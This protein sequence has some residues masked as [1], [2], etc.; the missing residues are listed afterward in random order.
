M[1]GTVINA[2]A[3]IAGSLLG[4]LIRGGLKEKYKEMVMHV[5]GLCVLFVGASSAL[6]GLLDAD[7]EPVLFIVS[8]VLG[9]LCGQW[10]DIEGRLERLGQILQNKIGNK[11]GNIAQGFVS[12][13]L[14]FCVGTMAVLGSL[15]SGI[16][17]DYT[18]L[19]AKSVIDGV[20][21]IV[22]ASTLGIGVA[23]SAAAVFLYQG[24]ITLFASF[25][26]SY[27]TADMLRE[28]SIVGGIMIFAIGL[29][30]LEIKK[31]KIGNA[32]PAILVPV[33]YYLPFVQ[34]WIGK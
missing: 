14:L 17:G 1:F 4:L 9:S 13:S 21:S 22:L 33:L 27:L 12:G 6:G 34:N 7:A 15:E 32:L 11:G 10:L 24:A 26:Q 16:Q 25:L 19:F 23:F 29:N 8:L 28:I 2:A 5:L 3:I 31:I 30:M 20:T 18:T